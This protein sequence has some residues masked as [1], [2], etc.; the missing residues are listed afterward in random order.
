M[1][2][3]QILEGVQ[4][5]GKLSV[6]GAKMC[7]HSVTYTFGVNPGKQIIAGTKYVLH[8]EMVKDKVANATKEAK[9]VA[10]ACGAMSV[11][12]IGAILAL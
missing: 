10:K 1:T 9:N 5:F 8:N 4:L 3:E 7:K 6:H 2:K 11:A 12:A